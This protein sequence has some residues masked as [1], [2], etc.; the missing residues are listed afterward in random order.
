MLD[1]RNRTAT[2]QVDQ[3]GNS[4]RQAAV[5][6]VR[7]TQ[8]RRHLLLLVL[9]NTHDDYDLYDVDKLTRRRKNYILIDRLI[10]CFKNA[11]ILYIDICS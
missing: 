6:Q 9:G 1:K 4:L 5:A 7:V 3:R 8:A 11:I 2:T 10:V